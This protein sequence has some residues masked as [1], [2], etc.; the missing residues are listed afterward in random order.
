MTSFKAKFPVLQELFAKNHR[1]GPLGPPPSGARVNGRLTRERSFKAELDAATFTCNSPQ[2]PVSGDFNRRRWRES[3]KYR[4]FWLAR[5][6]SGTTMPIF[7]IFSPN[8]A[9]WR[10]EVPFWI[11]FRLIHIKWSKLDQNS[12]A[13]FDCH[14]PMPRNYW[15][16]FH[17]LCTIR[18]ALVWNGAVLSF[19]PIRLIEGPQGAKR[20]QRA[21]V[22]SSALPVFS[23]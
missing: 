14:A 22:V 1:G 11:Y 5:P 19:I 10:V 17:E 13:Q 6:C 2:L 12:F 16:D 20:D 21:W 4:S 23:P 9:A 3:L 15:T 18:R 8:N 7:M